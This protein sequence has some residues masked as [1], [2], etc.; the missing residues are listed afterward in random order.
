MIDKESENYM[1]MQGVV[2]ELCRDKFKVLVDDTED[3]NVLCTVSG[4]IRISGVRIL[5]GDAVKILVS[6]YDTKMGRIIYRNKA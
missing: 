2:V 3:M 1:E 5:V 6:A 4:K